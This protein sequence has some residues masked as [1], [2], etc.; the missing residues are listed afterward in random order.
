MKDRI[1]FSQFSDEMSIEVN[2]WDI[3]PNELDYLSLSDCP[4]LIS[5]MIVEHIPFLAQI[6]GLP[7][8]H[9]PHTSQKKCLKK[10]KW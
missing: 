1:D 7:L 2:I 4:L 9:I 3:I 10:V 8:Q 6:M 5:R